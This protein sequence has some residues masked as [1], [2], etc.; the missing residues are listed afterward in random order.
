MEDNQPKVL[1]SLGVQDNE[2]IS[3]SNLEKLAESDVIMSEALAAPTIAQDKVV[4]SEQVPPPPPTNLPP[5]TLEPPP[6]IQPIDPHTGGEDGG[7][8][9]KKQRV[10]RQWPQCT[11]CDS[12]HGMRF[13]KIVDNQFHYLACDKCKTDEMKDLSRKCACSGKD[14]RYGPPGGTA[15]RCFQCKEEGMVNLRPSSGLCECGSGKVRRYGIPGQGRSNCLD[16]KSEGMLN[17]SLASNNAASTRRR[18]KTTSNP[19]LPSSSPPPPPTDDVSTA[20]GNAAAAA[21][22]AVVGSTEPSSTTEPSTTE[23]S[24]THNEVTT[25][26]KKNLSLPKKRKKSL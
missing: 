22:L 11:N 18:S 10:R 3:K 19:V 25:D 1:P 14:L 5:P 2:T 6:P 4:P 13:G 12:K 7:P 9:K 20:A 15:S 21:A 17:L 24:S 23:P 26:T 16:C 8:I